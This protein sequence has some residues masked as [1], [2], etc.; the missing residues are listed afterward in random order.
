MQDKPQD[1][2][3]DSSI[4]LVV[5]PVTLELGFITID[6]F[7]IVNERVMKIV[8][9]FIDQNKQILQKIQDDYNE[10][11]SKVSSINLYLG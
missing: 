2:E 3:G 1:D 8:N 7:K 10:V 6:D 4:A 9:S 11:Q 5:D